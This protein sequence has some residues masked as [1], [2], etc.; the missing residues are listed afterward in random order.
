MRIQDPIQLAHCAYNTSRDTT[1]ISLY[2][3]KT[4]FSMQE[5]SEELAE[6][7]A[8]LHREQQINSLA[9]CLQPL[10]FM[11][12]IEFCYVLALHYYQTYLSMPWTARKVA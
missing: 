4:E 7:H 2:Q 8:R 11:F 9:H 5:H 6:A 3:R 10:S 1:A 12:S